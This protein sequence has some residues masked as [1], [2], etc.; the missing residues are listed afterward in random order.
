MALQSLLHIRSA[1]NTLNPSQV[2]ELTEKPVHIS[3]HANS[4][5]AYQRME[6]FFL[7]ELRPARRTESREL[8][9]RGEATAAGNAHLLSVYDEAA[10]SPAGALV[11]RPD[12]PDHMVEKALVRH[13]QAGIVLARSF[14]PFRK[15]YVN[16]VIASTARE[17]V[18]FSMATALPDV[19][20]SIIE[21]P[22]AVAEFASDSAFLTMNQV[23]M[24]FHLAAASDREVGYSEQKSE[25]AGIVASAFGWRALAK[26]AVGKIPFGGGLIGKA[27]VAYA[28]TKVMGLSLDRLYSIGFAHSRGERDRLYAEAY[29]HGRKVAFRILGQIRPDLAAK[30]GGLDPKEPNEARFTS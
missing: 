20:P 15:P 5:D 8:L 18:L 7:Q 3:L 23:R 6:N 28:G 21:L 13:P 22:W 11:F 9:T 17:N 12:N 14:Y 26:Q 1:L 25:I 24:A 19:I 30:F 10:V 2:R 27:A 16:R 29:H 4:E